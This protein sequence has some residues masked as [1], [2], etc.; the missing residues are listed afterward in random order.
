MVSKT[1]KQNPATRRLLCIDGGGITGTFPAAV[2]ASLEENLDE[3]IGTYFDL[4]AGTSSGGI[5]A[6]GLSMGIRASDLLEMYKKH[7]PEIFGQS[8]NEPIR[9]FLIRKWRSIRHLYSNKYDSDALRKTL[10]A[11]LKDKLIGEAKTRLIIPAWNPAMQHVY[12]YKTAHHRRFPDDYQSLAVD[13][14]LATSA[15]PTYFRQHVTEDGIGLIDGG[16]WANNP[17]GLAA[18]EATSV[19]G[20]SPKS[21]RILSIGCLQEIYKTPDKMGL[22]AAKGKIIDM[23]MDGQSHG[24][25]EIAKLITGHE[26]QGHQS[27]YRIDHVVPEDQYRIDDITKINALKEFGSVKVRSEFPN[28]LPIFFQDKARRFNPCYKIQKSKEMNHVTR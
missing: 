28:L 24:A 25:L 20:W 11:V 2:L 15:A 17:I 8:Y 6:I 13:A 5:L 27:I 7:G 10:E 18:V 23:F 12:I 1:K 4:I 26:Y 21:I 16:I 3:P 22:L 19:L 14:A 9:N